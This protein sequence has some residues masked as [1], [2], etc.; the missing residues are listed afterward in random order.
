MNIKRFTLL[1]TSSLIV[2]AGVLSFQLSKEEVYFPR[3]ETLFNQEQEL[4]GGYLE[5]MNSIRNNR[6]TGFISTAEVNAARKQADRLAKRSKALDL[7]WRFKGPDNI[8]GR[9][10]AIIV[11]INDTNHIIAGG[12]SGGIWESFDAA[13]SW[14]PYDNDFKIKNVSSM[15][16]G[17]DGTIYVGTGSTFDGSSNNKS[18]GSHF[19]G[20]GIFKLTG[21]G[22]SEVLA[23]P[24][25]S[26]TFAEE[27]SYVNDI[28]VD[29]N[30]P[31]RIL[32]AM[33]RGLRESTDGG[34]TWNS[35]I[36][37]TNCY[38]VEITST[39]TI[40]AAYSGSIYTR[41]ASESNFTRIPFNG[42]DRIE[43]AVA[44]SDQTI[45][46]ASMARTNSCL[47][48]VYRSSDEGKTWTRLANTPDYFD[49]GLQC[50]GRY[51]NEIIVFPN[52]AGK[53]IVG[54]IGLYVWNQSSVDP[55]PVEGEW[56]VLASIGQFRFDG[57]RNPLYVHA[58]KHLFTFNPQNPNTMYLGT[59]GGVSVS[60]DIDRSQPSFSTSNLGYNV[61]QFYDIG[62]GPN[63]QVAGGTQDNGTL[64]M[65]LPFNTGKSAVQVR[66][67]DGFDTELFTINPSLGIASL[68]FG[69]IR[70]L[71]GLGTTLQETVPDNASIYTGSLL[72]ICGGEGAG[73]SRCGVPFYTSASIW[74]SFNHVETND[75][76]SVQL[77][78]KNLPPLKA[79]TVVP[80]N[81]KNNRIP[82]EGVLTSVEFPFDTLIGNISL[83][84][85]FVNNDDLSTIITEAFDTLAIDLVNDEIRI[86]RRNQ[87]IVTFPVVFGQTETYNNVFV[88]SDAGPALKVRVDSI[89]G[90]NGGSATYYV[91]FDQAQVTFFYR[92][93]FPDIVQSMVALANVSGRVVIPER[94]VWITRDVLKGGDIRWFKVAGRASLPSPMPFE[95]ALANEFSR[96]GDHLFIGTALGKLIR[97]DNLNDINASQIPIT[98]D[99]EFVVNNITTATI[100]ANFGNNRA[101]TGI[102]IDPNDGNNVIVTIGNY[103]NSGYVRRSTNALSANPTFEIIDGVG[104]NALPASPA[105]DAVIDR[106]DPNKVLIGTEFGVFGTENAF[107]TAT[108]ID[109][110]TGNNAVDVRWTEENNGMGRAPVFAIDQMIFGATE[111]AINEGKIYIGTHGRGVFETDQLVGVE[112]AIS[113]S[114]KKS[115][116]SSLMVYPNPVRDNANLALHIVN[117][118][119]VIIQ[120]YSIS[121]QLVSNLSPQNLKKGDNTFEV[122]VNDLKN[123]TYLIRLIDGSNVSSGKFIKQ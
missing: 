54:G 106:R 17:S 28:E 100:I 111:G 9:T 53:I 101:V 103:G 2:M 32:A 116:E 118:S 95:N 109:P 83:K 15:A 48:G 96:D 105:Y 92:F 85:E 88:D 112:N 55:A 20:T 120:I 46:Y 79:G 119:S 41:T 23:E 6:E 108:V 80:Y 43:L 114:D 94:N 97:I 82:L 34:Q 33:D 90:S 81:S 35:L 75:S 67:G 91:D 13:Q 73:L 38:D 16:Q 37:V 11:D 63:D 7:T 42:A 102:A 36:A 123:G 12:V 113:S 66:G 65:G 115:N 30:N 51:D 50:Q 122:D 107:E 25:T 72:T 58:D 44:P 74:E 39:G 77:E 24:T 52:N 5:F 86:N 59:D 31:Q 93:E 117:P 99:D 121:G 104:V 27:W 45:M 56:K 110:V 21:N 3:T 29:P 40:V 1:A 69:D 49:V 89:P 62:V 19:L 14:Q 18:K 60:F 70:R 64:F 61:T 26:N 68:Y 47:F 57:T 87:G 84:R 71:Q 76:V 8:G 78:E 98:A 22:N 4:A 10:R